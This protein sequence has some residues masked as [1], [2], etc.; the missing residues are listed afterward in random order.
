MVKILQLSLSLTTSNLN[1]AGE[2][3]KKLGVYYRI[4]HVSGPEAEKLEEIWKEPDT[5]LGTD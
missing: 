2:L 1:H 3:Q 4:A 5:R